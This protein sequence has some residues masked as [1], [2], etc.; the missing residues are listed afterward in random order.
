MPS[1]GK[2]SKVLDSRKEPNGEKDSQ[3]KGLPYSRTRRLVL[4]AV[5]VALAVALHVLEGL[6]PVPVPVPGA[7]LGLANI[8]TLITLVMFG[9]KESLAVVLLRVSIGT[10]FGGSF[11]GLGF[12]LAMSGAVFSLII[13]YLLLAFCRSLSIIGVSVAGAVAHNLAQV[14]VAGI[15]TQTPQLFFVLPVLLLIAVPA[16]SF[17]G[18]AAKTVLHYLKLLHR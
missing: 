18:I 1:S 11:M 12:L 9:W 5:F 17:T 14:T 4:L 7:K 3:Q 6:V 10:L 2:T 13:M 16:G 15:L 8:V